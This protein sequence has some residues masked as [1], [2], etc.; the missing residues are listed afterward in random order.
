MSGSS[1]LMAE[2]SSLSESKS[3]VASES[4]VAVGAS[5]NRWLLN[6]NGSEEARSAPLRLDASEQ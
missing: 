1:T 4:C 6:A 3:M 5:L 2:E